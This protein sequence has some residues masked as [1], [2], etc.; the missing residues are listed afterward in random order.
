VN[1]GDQAL[2]FIY[3]L[4]VLA[5]VASAFGVRRIP[6]AQTLKMLLAWGFIFGAVF[7]FI[8][9]KYE[10]KALGKR[11]IGGTPT[12]VQQGETLRIR[13]NGDGHFWVDANV[14]GTEA[15][16]LVD[17]GATITT[18]S[19]ETAEKA[20]VERSD[21]FG[22]MVET[23][24]G[25]VTVGRGRARSFQVG[26]I[27]REDMRVHLSAMD[28]TNLIGMNFLSTLSGWSVEGDT[29]ILRP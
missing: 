9:L 22:A 27:V 15:R 6:I 23:A 28:E 8:S 4:L 25:T 26:G 20:G 2:H 17:S 1:D 12:M 5:L 24:N 13:R 3:L 18:L 19:A 11:V 7:V 16:F 14:N 29:L 10:F 21:P